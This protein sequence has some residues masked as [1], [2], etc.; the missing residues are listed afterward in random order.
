MLAV[1]PDP[2]LERRA[3]ELPWD[4]LSIDVEPGK[5]MRTMDLTQLALPDH[6]RDL[7]ICYHV[8]EHIPDDRAAMGEIRRVLRPEGQAI[9]QVP[10]AAEETDEEFRDAPPAVRAERYGQPDHVRLYGRT[11]FVRR[12]AAAGLDAEEILVGDMFAD[13]AEAA[14]LMVE[15]RFFVARPAPVGRAA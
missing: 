6:D 1:A 7:L 2:Y 14:A 12:L 11:D 4:Y 5:A 13:Q 9:V 10:L 8:L 15:E 3:R